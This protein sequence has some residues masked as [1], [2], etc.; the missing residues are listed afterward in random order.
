MPRGGKPPAGRPRPEAEG[1]SQPPATAATH[2]AA[3]TEPAATAS[4]TVR[5]IPHLPDMRSLL[6]TRRCWITAALSFA[7]SGPAPPTQ[8]PSRRVDHQPVRIQQCG[9]TARSKTPSSFSPCPMIGQRAQHRGEAVG[10]TPHIAPHPEAAS[11]HTGLTRHKQ[12]G[13]PRQQTRQPSRVQ[14]EPALTASTISTPAAIRPPDTHPGRGHRQSHTLT[15]RPGEQ[16]SL[17]PAWG[18]EMSAA[19]PRLPNTADLHQRPPSRIGAGTYAG[20]GAQQLGIE[21]GLR[22]ILRGVT[23]AGLPIIPARLL[24]SDQVKLAPAHRHLGPPAVRPVRG[25]LEPHHRQRGPAP[26]LP[27][28]GQ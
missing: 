19:H 12:D 28:D 23:C 7:C 26:A 3:T 16:I 10:S 11:Q 8:R 6:N 15:E 4:I 25:W 5:A 13:P 27:A 20:T 21:H 14:A 2:T 17:L 1:S 9:R 18:K 22:L 24:P